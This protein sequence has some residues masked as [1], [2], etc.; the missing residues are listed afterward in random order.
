MNAAA[1]IHPQPRTAATA[2]TP[3]TATATNAN[4]AIEA[5]API[6][7]GPASGKTSP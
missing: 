2:I 4:D 3:I 1:G 5:S 7:S 6:N